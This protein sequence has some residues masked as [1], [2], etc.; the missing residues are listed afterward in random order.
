MNL[1]PASQSFLEGGLFSGES[2]GP[3]MP[4]PTLPI[5]INPTFSPP[6]EWPMKGRLL[7]AE[8]CGRRRAGRLPG[9]AVSATLCWEIHSH[10][11]CWAFCLYYAQAPSAEYVIPFSLIAL[12][13]FPPSLSTLENGEN[14]KN[15]KSHLTGHLRHSW[16][17]E[18]WSIS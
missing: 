15:S 17:S 2:R 9:S 5:R 12:L 1:V 3:G 16:S 18:F 11:R 13:Q 14:G 10:S 8:E 4:E 7:R 6:P